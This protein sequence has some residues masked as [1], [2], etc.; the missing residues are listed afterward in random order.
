MSTDQPASSTTILVVDDDPLIAMTTVDMLEDLGHRVIEANSGAEALDVLKREPS[1]DLVITDH[2]MPQMTGAE[3]AIAAL[4][5]RPGLPILLSTGYAD[6]P[7]GF[8]LDLPR[9]PK[10]F[11]QDQLQ[12]AVDALLPNR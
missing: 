10:P 4:E 2:S 12:K 5:L 9:L 3:L 6:L 1:I 7:P 8:E 11:Q